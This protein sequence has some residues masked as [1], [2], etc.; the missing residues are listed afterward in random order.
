MAK[1][2][3]WVRLNVG[4]DESSWLEDLPWAVRA[5]WPVILCHVKVFGSS[6]RCPVPSWA[7]F[8]GGHDIPADLVKALVE[9]AT[10]DGA[11]LIEDGYMTVSNWNAYQ[12]AESTDR[13]AKL[14]EKKKAAVVTDG[15]AGN[16]TPVTRPRRNVTPDDETLPCHATETETGTV[17]KTETPSGRGVGETKLRPILMEVPAFAKSPPAAGKLDEIL[18]DFSELGDAA[19]LRHAKAARD[20]ALEPKT[21]YAKAPDKPADGVKFLRNWLEKELRDQHKN[22]HGKPPEEPERPPLRYTPEEL[23]RL[24]S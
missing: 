11:L 2:A 15:N 10:A 9:A 18:E 16:V 20:W 22:G 3:R 14:R 17:T 12:G 5:V 7:R 23:E 1:D 13:V 4:W 21:R 24:T 6:G 8:A 19:I